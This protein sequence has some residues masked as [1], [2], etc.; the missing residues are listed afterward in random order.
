MF[1]ARVVLGASRIQVL[2]SVLNRLDAELRE[3]DR[4]VSYSH[5]H[6]KFPKV[7]VVAR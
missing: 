7:V 5:T 3:T 2:G 1:T 6:T 4:D